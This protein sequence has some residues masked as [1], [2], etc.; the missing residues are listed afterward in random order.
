MYLYSCTRRLAG[1]GYLLFISGR[2]SPS[3]PHACAHTC[4]REE[5]S[6]LH[7]KVNKYQTASKN[8]SPI[9]A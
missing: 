9:D 4:F 6:T 7:E 5:S 1:A 3:L 2:I 8:T